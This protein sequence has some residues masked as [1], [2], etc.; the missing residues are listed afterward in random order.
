MDL[1]LKCISSIINKDTLGYPIT[2]ISFNHDSKNL[3]F[4]AKNGIYKIYH[5]AS[6]EYILN[7]KIINDYVIS[8]LFNKD[9]SKLIIATKKGDLI[10][11]NSPNYNQIN[12]K[13]QFNIKINTMKFS[14]L[15]KEIIGISF[16]DGSIKIFNLS[17]NEILFSFNNIHLGECTSISFSPVHKSFLCTSGL[18]GKI[19]FYDFEKEKRQVTSINTGKKITSVT[20]VEKGDHIL[21]SDENG[22]VYLY[23]LRNSREEKCVFKGNKGKIHYIEINRKIEK[24]GNNN[25]NNNVNNNNK[26]ENSII[27]SSSSKKNL[28]SSAKNLNKVQSEINNNNNNNDDNNNN[29]NEIEINEFKNSLNNSNNNIKQNENLIKNKERKINEKNEILNLY[30]KESFNNNNKNNNNN[31]INNNFNNNNNNYNEDQID[32]NMKKYIEKVVKENIKEESNKIKNYIHDE[33]TSLHVDIIKQFEIQQNKMMNIIKTF[34]LLNSKMAI[35]IEE[36]EKENNELKSQ[37]F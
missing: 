8:I 3:A 27:N 28:M 20:F 25:N 37:F 36:L 2:S 16:E 13:I 34:S 6:D 7:G 32:L 18:D 17:K 22:I 4:S 29:K 14:S 35:K 33:I 31:I 15:L 9:S 12:I 23:D 19:N 30:K 1:N 10:S 26:I 5:L 21:C 11:Y 24:I